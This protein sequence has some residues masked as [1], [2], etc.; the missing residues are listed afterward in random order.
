MTTIDTKEARAEGVI[1]RA[2][3]PGFGWMK[4]AAAKLMIAA[5]KGAG[6][7]IVPVDPTPMTALGESAKC[8]AAGQQAIYLSVLTASQQKVDRVRQADGEIGD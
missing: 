2:M 5:L 1:A 8:Q 7:V 3:E 6:F 4:D